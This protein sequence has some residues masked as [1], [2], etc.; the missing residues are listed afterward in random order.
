M[1]V[2]WKNIVGLMEVI[3]RRTKMERMRKWNVWTINLTVA[4]QEQVHILWELL[5]IYD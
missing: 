2:S 1:L 5:L 3:V 4:S